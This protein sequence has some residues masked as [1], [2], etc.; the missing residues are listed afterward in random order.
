[1]SVRH[2]LAAAALSAG[3]V[4]PAAAL[5]IVDEATLVLSYGATP[6]ERFQECGG[7]CDFAAAFTD[8]TLDP[9]DSGLGTLNSVRI[10]AMTFGLYDIDARRI[11]GPAGDFSYGYDGYV[12]R[13]A[14]L[15]P[16]LSA[17]VGVVGVD[18]ADSGTVAL[19]ESGWTY[20]ATLDAADSVDVTLT[21]PALLALL[22]GADP[23]DIRH[24]YDMDFTF[25]GTLAYSMRG[26]AGDPVPQSFV[27][28]TYDYTPF[29]APIPLP[30]A[31]W[32]L[33]AGLGALA[34]ARR[35]RG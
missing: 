30:A 21:D 9:F 3:T 23:I 31:G 28:V 26:S 2:V 5:T 8:G 34:V 14:F 20:I 18:H 13:F 11:S 17:A 12:A 32:L 25:A 7:A 24:S 6:G 15:D 27:R 1:M 33:L 16:T 4:A 19:A 35:R 29:S 10:E 22:S